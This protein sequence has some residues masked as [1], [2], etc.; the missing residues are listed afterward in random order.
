MSRKITHEEYRDEIK[1]INSYV[2]S[3]MRWLPEDEQ[4][5]CFNEMMNS[6]KAQY[7]ESCTCSKSEV[8]LEEFIGRIRPSGNIDVTTTIVY[9]KN[10]LEKMQFVTVDDVRNAYDELR[11]SP[12]ADISQNLREI[13]S[14]KYYN[15]I[16]FKSGLA[17][18][19]AKG[20]KYVKNLDEYNADSN[21]GDDEG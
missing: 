18:I 21:L 6:L 16:V 3:D 20:I 14:K 7:E 17:S 13:A 5:K 10:E 8:S 9:Y 4:I 12:P 11:I 1:K 15:R 2:R 19:T